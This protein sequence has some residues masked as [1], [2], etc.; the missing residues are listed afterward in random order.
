MVLTRSLETAWTRPFLTIF[1]FALFGAKLELVE[2]ELAELGIVAEPSKPE[3]AGSETEPNRTEPNPIEPTQPEQNR[4]DPRRTERIETKRSG[5]ERFGLVRFWL[6]FRCHFCFSSCV[7]RGMTS[8]RF[9]VVVV[10][11]RFCFLFVSFSVLCRFLHFILLRFRFISS[12]TCLIS[13]RF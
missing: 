4:I 13:F 7:G 8:F 12:K 6:R 9:F 11:F 5:T 1:Q 3:S 2:Q 10:S